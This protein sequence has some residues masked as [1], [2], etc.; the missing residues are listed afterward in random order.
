MPYPQRYRLGR[1]SNNFLD[2]TDAGWSDLCRWHLPLPPV[3]TTRVAVVID[4][5]SASGDGG[6]L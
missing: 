5:E 3:L 1:L 6:E 4:L 2:A